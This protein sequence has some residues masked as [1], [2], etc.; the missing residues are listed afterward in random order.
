MK[1]AYLLGAAA[2]ALA[3]STSAQAVEIQGKVNL[4]D[5]YGNTVN[6]Q[7]S[8]SNNGLEINVK[9][10]SSATPYQFTTDDLTASP[11]NNTD[12]VSL[13]KISTPES[14]VNLGE[15]TKLKSI[16]AQFSFLSPGDASGLSDTIS[17]STFGVWGLIQEGKVV[18]GSPLEFTYGFH[19]NGKFRLT[20]LDT[21]F[22]SGFLGLGSKGGIVQGKFELL[23]AAGAVPE[24]STWAMMILGVGF[25]G[26]AMRRRRETVSVRY[27]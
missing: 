5:Y 1:T 6:E 2:A 23:N 7:G 18:W 3:L 25:A 19:N 16:K 22:N 17:G 10:I 21:T 9:P 15:D 26:A 11:G 14:S 8:N 24:P 20:L 4:V 13:F 12:V 27:A